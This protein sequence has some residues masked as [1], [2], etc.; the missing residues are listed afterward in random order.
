MLAASSSGLYDENQRE[1]DQVRD[2]LDALMRELASSSDVIRDQAKAL[3]EAR[4]D[5][6][7]HKRCGELRHCLSMWLCLM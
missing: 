2:R 1:L 7:D 5:A 3:M 6:D 4:N